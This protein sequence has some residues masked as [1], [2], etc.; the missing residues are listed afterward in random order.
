ML[1][2]KTKS[3]FLSIVICGIGK[4][5]RSIHVVAECRVQMNR[6]APVNGRSCCGWIVAL[7]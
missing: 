5:F 7:P 2:F 1:W 4:Y 3:F 6:Q